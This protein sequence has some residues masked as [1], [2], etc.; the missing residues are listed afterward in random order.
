MSCILWPTNPVC[1]ECNH[2]PGCPACQL[3]S[4]LNGVLGGVG[5]TADGFRHCIWTTRRRSEVDQR[6]STV[7][8]SAVELFALPVSSAASA[9]QWNL[10]QDALKILQD[11]DVPREVDMCH[12]IHDAE[13]GQMVVPE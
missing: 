9:D 5:E 4:R 3:L 6:R 13:T 1:Q 2:L 12:L 10:V 8:A 7:S 11:I